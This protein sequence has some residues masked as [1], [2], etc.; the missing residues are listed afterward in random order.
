M[1]ELLIGNM[2]KTVVRHFR[3]SHTKGGSTLE[4]LIAFAILIS[5]I[6]AVIMVSFGNQS[7]AVDTITN[8]EALYK[9]HALLEDARVRSRQNFFD[10]VATTSTETSGA[11][12][13]TKT[14]GVADLSQ[15]TKEATSTITWSSTSLR[16]QQITLATSLTDVSGAIALGGDCDATPLGG[17]WN[18]PAE[19]AGFNIDKATGIDVAYHF[20]YLALNKT[21]TSSDDLAIVDVTSSTSPILVAHVDV[22]R[23]PGFNSIDVATSTDGHLYAYIAN[24]DPVGQLLIMDVTK[25]TAPIFVASSTLSGI[26]TGVGRSIFYYDK[27]VYIGTKYFVCAGCN[28]LH[29]YDVSVPSAPAPI[30]SINV[31]RNVNSIFVRNGLAYLATGPGTSPTHNPL[32]IFDVNPSSPTYRLEVGSFVATGDEEGTAV[33]VLGNKLYLGLERATG[34]RPDLYVL[35]V[36]QPGAITTFASTNLNLNSSAKV[37]GIRVAGNLGY[38]ATSDP[39][40]NLTVRDVSGTTLGEIGHFNFA[41]TTTGLDVADNTVYLSSLSGSRSLE[42]VGPQP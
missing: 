16:P 35:D 32:K 14:L 24:N 11:L 4:I 34:G 42:I 40:S 21:P 29:I 37:V 6:S 19:R 15:C 31:N 1:R 17:K 36:A 25:P 28:E 5:A 20:A 41:Q 27:K 38:I 9:A 26:T 30:T 33:Y 7:I 3:E 39:N 23:E 12:T 10:V 8:S 18:P 2:K 22:K 13:Y